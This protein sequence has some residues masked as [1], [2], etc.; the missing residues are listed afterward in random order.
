VVISTVFGFIAQVAL[1]GF[2][3]AYRWVPAWAPGFGLLVYA[4]GVPAALFAVTSPLLG[5][6]WPAVAALGLYAAWSVFG[7][8]IDVIR[9][10]A[11]RVPPR[12]P[13]LVPYALLLTASLLC[14]WVPLWFVDRALWVVFGLLYAT[15]TTLNAASHRRPSAGP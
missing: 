13:I 12:W 2:F 14:F 1:L 6:A 10:I 3:A 4:L 5:L 9:P 15:H 7:A 11:W 8:W